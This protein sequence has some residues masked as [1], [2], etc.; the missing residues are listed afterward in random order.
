[1]TTYSK[2]SREEPSMVGAVTLWR[3]ASGSAVEA[4]SARR[5]SLWSMSVV[6]GVVSKEG[7]GEQGSR[8]WFNGSQ[9]IAIF[10]IQP[11]QRYDY[12][13][14]LD[15]PPP[16]SSLSML[17]RMNYVSTWCIAISCGFPLVTIYSCLV[18]LR[19]PSILV[20][21]VV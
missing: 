3:F 19:T 10:A 13:A 4:R 15:P 12:E 20:K 11:Q 14:L 6:E 18:S 7:N 5:M 2:V 21:H 9:V 17:C 16:L 1:V 8:R